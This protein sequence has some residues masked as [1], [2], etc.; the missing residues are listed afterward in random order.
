MVTDKFFS[1]ADGLRIFYRDYTGK[2]SIPILCLPG[3][4]RNSRDFS[5][6]A[7]R[8]SPRYRVLTPDLRGRGRSDWDPLWHRYHPGTYVADLLAL[9]QHAQV[10]RFVII[11]TSLGGI[12]GM[13]I[14][15]SLQQRVAGLIL[16]DVGPEVS[17]DA[18]SRISQY[19]GRS[20]PVRNWN[21]AADQARATY[22]NALPEYT[23]ED[24]LR[25]ARRSYSEDSLGI[26]TLDMD[27]RIGDAARAASGTGPT[28][29]L[30]PIWATLRSI[31]LLTIRGENSDVLSAATLARMAAEMPELQTLI[32]A[33]RG[34]APTLDEPVC[35]DAIERFLEIRIGSPS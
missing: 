17:R 6:L 2:H 9:L 20:A 34:H 4:T 11:G 10:S 15:A 19:V 32:V 8:L 35:I 29:D 3:L 12:L 31:P 30:W 33:N 21:E 18:V 22:G 16:N 13:L 28:P 23:H 14:A 1:T 27:P 26:P 7:E 24:W 25:Y 5:L